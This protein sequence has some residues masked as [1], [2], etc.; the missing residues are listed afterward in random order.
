M[1]PKKILRRYKGKVA[2]GKVPKIYIK[3]RVT[4][5]IIRVVGRAKFPKEVVAFEVQNECG[6]ISDE[7]IS[8][9]NMGRSV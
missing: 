8:C 6:S 2:S 4:I 5:K 1:R 9:Q 7:N 3:D